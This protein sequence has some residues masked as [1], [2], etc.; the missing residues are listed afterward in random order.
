MKRPAASNPPAKPRRAVT[1]TEPA[2]EPESAKPAKSAPPINLDHLG[3]DV[4]IRERQLL[5]SAVIVSRATFLRWLED[6]LFPKPIRIGSCRFW[7]VGDVRQWLR[8]QAA[9][10]IVGGVK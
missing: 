8:D 6:E 1:K 7:R 5:S 4:L 2:A 10:N 3:D 9:K